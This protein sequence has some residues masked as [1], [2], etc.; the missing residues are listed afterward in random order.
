MLVRVG[1]DDRNEGAAP[2][3]C[4]EHV[5][6]LA[7]VVLAGD[8]AHLDSECRRCGAVMVETPQELRGEV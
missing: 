8:G 3:E 4:V 2:G 5:W 7:G 1:H 6:M